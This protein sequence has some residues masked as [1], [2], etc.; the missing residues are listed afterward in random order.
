MLYASHANLAILDLL[1]C[2]FNKI[3]EEKLCFCV[4]LSFSLISYKICRITN[5][6]SFYLGMV[7]IFSL[8][9][10]RCFCYL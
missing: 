3:G 9:L 8:I 2:L 10:K 5:A 7:Q 4:M 1:G 6:L